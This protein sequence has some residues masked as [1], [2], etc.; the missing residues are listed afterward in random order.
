MTFPFCSCIALPG[1]F[2][3]LLISCFCWALLSVLQY[4]PDC[5]IC[6]GYFEG[7]AL[8]LIFYP[9]ILSHLS[10]WSFSPTLILN[11]TLTCDTLTNRHKY[12][13]ENQACLIFRYLDYNMTSFTHSLFAHWWKNL[14][15]I[16]NQ[17]FSSMPVLDYKMTP[18]ASDTLAV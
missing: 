7:A 12:F 16:L 2:R 4:F 17:H 1:V 15:I 3:P 10:V 6:L 9:M 13:E 11:P 14:H 8:S 5:C 18:W